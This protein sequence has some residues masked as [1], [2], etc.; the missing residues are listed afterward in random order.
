MDRV[1]LLEIIEPGILASVQD[2]GRQGYRRI[3]VAPSGAADSYACRIGNLLVGNLEDAA[4]V[5]ITL[6]GIE[7]RFRHEAVVAVTGADLGAVLNGAPRSAPVTAT[8]ASRRKR[9]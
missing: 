2:V 4:A 7:A 5:E 6:M 8:T 3:G 1:N 9:A